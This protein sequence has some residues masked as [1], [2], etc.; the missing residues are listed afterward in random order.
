MKKRVLFVNDEMQMGGVA[1][2][3][4]TLLANLDRNQYE[5][6]L[7][8][9]HH[10]GAMLNEIP[11]DIRVLK[12]S[13]FFNTIDIPLKQCNLKQLFSKL[14]LLFYMKTGLIKR[15]IQSE[16][17]KIVPDCYDIEFSAKEGFCTIFTAFGDSKRKLNWVQVD[18]KQS[19]YS[20]NHMKLVYCALQRIDLNIAC[21]KQVQES[22]RQLF[23]IENIVVLK[24]LIDQNRIK[25]LSL[26]NC[27]IEVG[28]NKI[29][30]ICV[31]R[32]HPQKGLDRL[33]RVFAKLQD[34]YQLSIIGDGE[35]K[36]ELYQLASD[37][38]VFEK[39][40]WLGFQTNPY[41]YIRC[42]DLFVMPSVYEGYP[43]ITIESLIC[44]TPVLSTEVAGI[45]SQLTR[46]EYGFIVGNDEEAIYHKL[47]ELKNQKVLLGQ[48]KTQLLSYVY[49]NE[50]ILKQ[51]DLYFNQSKI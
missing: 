1:R 30:L 44:T 18:Y 15:K 6:D 37:L 13:A 21:S 16:R 22:Y 31:A 47:D 40:N 42:A 38:S 51:L 49:D 36:E 14:R 41:Q 17:K 28:K 3:L 39:I 12:G 9:L 2:I 10:H 46:P 45:A 5:I 7:L 27:N 19:N 11:N 50:S 8:V 43:T 4:N 25:Q 23:P 33:I 34:Y 32:F 26:I 48:Y 20:K 29:H 24:N 35:L